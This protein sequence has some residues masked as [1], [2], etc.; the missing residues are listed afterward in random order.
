MMK[1]GPTITKLT[2]RNCKGRQLLMGRWVDSWRQRV[3]QLQTET[4][5]IHL[6]YKDPRVPWYAKILIALAVAHTL[7]PIDLVPDFIPILG[8]LDDLVIAPL[9]ISLALKMIPEDV[10]AKSREKAQAIVGH[11]KPVGWAAAAVII[12]IWLFVPALVIASIWR[13]FRR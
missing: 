11:Y 7:S 8:Y 3:G 6:A 1:R 5:A 4:Y 13:T 12:A 10:M 9:G 2:E